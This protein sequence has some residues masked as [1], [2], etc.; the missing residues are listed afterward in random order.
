MY[1]D[2]R[3]GDYAFK[4]AITNSPS[5][6]FYA[7]EH[8]HTSYEL[9]FVLQGDVD[10]VV[11][12]RTSIR[13]DPGVL[14]VF[15]PGEFHRLQVHTGAMYERVILRFSDTELS[16]RLKEKLKTTDT[17]YY[18]PGTKLV[19]EILR[20]EQLN[21]IFSQDA[22]S[23]V[24]IHQLH[25]ILNLLTETASGSRNYEVNEDLE[26]VLQFIDLHI[27]E[28]QSIYDITANVNMSRS[29]IQKLMSEQLNSSIMGYVRTKKCLL[30]K[31]RMKRGIPATTVYKE[32][33]FQDYSTFY[34]AYRKTFGT[35]PVNK[36]RRN[37]E[38]EE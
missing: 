10:V 27:P 36:E 18:I 29:K 1:F 20:L 5:K 15:K 31:E 21:D 17:F 12:H 34:R 9:M 6:N 2:V 23:E 33:G 38:K 22:I 7:S 25:I 4:Y 37:M 16:E 28:I 30:A 19:E 26:K 35:S 14:V 3:V 11:Q 8:Y 24:F 32:C 13:L